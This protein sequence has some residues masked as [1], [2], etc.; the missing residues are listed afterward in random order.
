MKEGKSCGEDG[1]TPEIIKRCDLD[2]ILLYFCN[3]A[4]EGC[5]PNLWTISNII[6]VPKTGDLTNPTN[7][8][9]ISLTSVAAKVFN[10]LILNRIRPLIEDKLRINQN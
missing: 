6:P 4:L 10:K 2:D 1:I 8:R 7:Y 5:I 3:Q 9:G